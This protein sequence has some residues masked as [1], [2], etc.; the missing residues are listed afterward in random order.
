MDDASGQMTRDFI[1]AF[2]KQT[3]AKCAIQA[4]LIAM[5]M[6]VEHFVMMEITA[7]RMEFAKVND[8]MVVHVDQEKSKVKPVMNI[9]TV[10]RV[11]VIGDGANESPRFPLCIMISEMS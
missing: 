9:Q 4:Y 11:I 8:A 6:H 10:F 3:L 5:D 1:T 7:R 2:L